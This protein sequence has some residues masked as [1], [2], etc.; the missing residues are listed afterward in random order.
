MQKMKFQVANKQENN[1]KY[2]KIVM[3]LIIMSAIYFWSSNNSVDSENTEPFEIVKT[4][5]AENKD[6]ENDVLKTVNS[7]K[8]RTKISQEKSEILQILQN[9]SNDE[10][11]HVW[12][13]EYSCY[14]SQA[15]ECKYSFLNAKSL[16]EAK[17]MRN[18]GYPIR[19]MLDLINDASRK[20][21]LMEL[22]KDK[23]PAALTVASISAMERGDYREASHL[24]LSNLVHSDKSKTYPHLLYG[25]AL[26]LDNKQPLA[27]PQIYV[28]GLLGD[29]LAQGRATSLSGD[30]HVS[31]SALNSA[32]GYLRRVFGGQAP[33]NP[34]PTT[35]NG[36]G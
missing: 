34:R 17:W 28:A 14:Y 24:A 4:K 21:E 26:V 31:T 18:N 30:V 29:S 5:V 16:D 35:G 36:G 10:L 1:M 23:Y 22:V 15:G 32:H 25:E 2:F 13:K 7:K 33:K 20:Q 8:A 27:L 19:S 3:L 9:P 12:E 6:H 11:S